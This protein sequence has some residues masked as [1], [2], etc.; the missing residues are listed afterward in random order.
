VL[1]AFI[2]SNPAKEN[3]WSFTYFTRRDKLPYRDKLRHADQSNNYSFSLELLENRRHQLRTTVTYRELRIKDPALTKLTPDNSLLGRVEYLVNEWKGLL[4]GSVL[5]ELGAGQ[6]QRRD[7]SF[8]EVPAGRG[9]YAWIDYNS[10]GIP[11]LSEFEIALF[12]DQAKYIRIFTPTNEFIKANYTQFNYSLN[13][14]PK[15]AASSIKNVKWKNFIT[16]F[17]LQ[18]SL[19]AG[20]KV[21]SDGDPEF[22][23]FK[24]N[25]ADQSL[26]TLN[27]IV[28]NTISFN[29]SSSAWGLDA[30]NITTYNKAILTYGFETRELS[31]WIFKGRVNIGG[32][33]TFELLQ[34]F[35][36]NNLYTPKFANRNYALDIQT[37]EPRLIYTH[38]TRFRLQASYQFIKKENSPLYGGEKALSNVLTFDGKFN[39]A[40][41][42]SINGRFS[43]NKISY[44]GLSNTAT[45][46]IMLDG[47]LPGR[48]LLWLVDIT[49]RLSN[50]LE[51]SVQYEGRKPGDTRSI[52]IGRAS[53][54]ALL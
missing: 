35:G 50:N 9:E 20:K 39:A 42:T 36:D 29:R 8:I 32:R 54:R 21:L 34:K 33:Y 11:Q 4:T 46:Y 12:S 1:S 47:L 13:L 45:G 25:V 17:N 19:Q 48:N 10:D 24:G 2:K 49:K 40:Q 14:N 38:L 28:S 6:E 30:T 26:I 3:R 31:D 43:Y 53:V 52:H 41:R 51:L 44:N 23:P 27:Y 18:S 5:Y 37:T 7:Y 22:N 15:A 16:R